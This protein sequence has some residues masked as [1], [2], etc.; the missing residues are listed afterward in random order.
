MESSPP[1]TVTMRITRH[2]KR[3]IS[4]AECVFGQEVN[5]STRNASDGDMLE[6]LPPAVVASQEREE[7]LPKLFEKKSLGGGRGNSQCH[8][9]MQRTSL[10]AQCI[11]IGIT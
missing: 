9:E 4:L 6:S 8:Q 3:G 1:V 7:C 10:T 5:V 2:A 11:R